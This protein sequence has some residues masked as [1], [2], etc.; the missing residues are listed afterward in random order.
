MKTERTQNQGG[1]GGNSQHHRK[2]K[3][4]KQKKLLKLFGR[5]QGAGRGI[6]RGVYDNAFISLSPKHL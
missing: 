3:Q 2:K 4:K 5:K 6:L 1:Y